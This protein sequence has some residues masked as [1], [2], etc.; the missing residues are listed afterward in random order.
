MTLFNTDGEAGRELVEKAP[1]GIH[2]RRKKGGI[3][4]AQPLEGRREILL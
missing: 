4:A 3:T 1:C 2:R